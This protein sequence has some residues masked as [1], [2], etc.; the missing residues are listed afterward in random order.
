MTQDLNSEDSALYFYRG[1]DVLDLR[2]CSSEEVMSINER[3]YDVFWCLQKFSNGRRIKENLL[4][5]NYI[6]ADFDNVSSEEFFTKTKWTPKPTMLVKTR[7]GYH[8]YWKIYDGSANKT[9]DEYRTLVEER[10]LPIGADPNAKDVCR[11]L[12]VPESRYWTS[13]KGERFEEQEIICKTIYDDGPE[14]TWNQISR[15][16]PS[17]LETTNEVTIKKTKPSKGD[18]SFWDK[19]NQIDLEEGIKKISGLACVKSQVFTVKK[20]GKIKRLYVN[21]KK[22]NGWIDENGRFGSLHDNTAGSMVNFLKFPE[23]GLENADIAKIFKE[24]FYVK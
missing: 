1:L 12:R 21:G 10:L 20:E 11:I 17:V 14:W 4:K 13:S 16:F 2:P 3:G 6:C 15:L 7:S 5:I 19:C 22:S 23:Y 8:A 18:E 24:V 9:P